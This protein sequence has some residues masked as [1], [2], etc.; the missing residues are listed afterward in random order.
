MKKTNRNRSNKP[1]LLQ[2]E[3][4]RIL[5]GLKLTEVAGG[6]LKPSDPG[7]VCTQ[8]SRDETDCC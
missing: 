6:I 8:N 7:D 3:T 4:I 5:S 2:M 1:L